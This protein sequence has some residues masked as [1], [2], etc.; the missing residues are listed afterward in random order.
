MENTGEKS[1]S[2]RI[3]Q[4]YGSNCNYPKKKNKT[5]LVMF[6]SSGSRNHRN[7]WDNHAGNARMVSVCK[8]GEK[9]QS[10]HFL[11][12]SWASYQRGVAMVLSLGD[13]PYNHG[14]SVEF[15]GYV[16]T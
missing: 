2:D 16:T 12:R 6:N 10:F 9:K 7:K 8:W 14:I 4:C 15:S 1:F 5:V 13:S 11:G 3:G